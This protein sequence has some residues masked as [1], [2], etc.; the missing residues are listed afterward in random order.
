MTYISQLTKTQ[1]GVLSATFGA[2]AGAAGGYIFAAKKLESFYKERADED[3]AEMKD[4]YARRYKRDD[5][6]DPVDLVK[7]VE[8]IEKSVDT[9]I[10]DEPET[11][12]DEYESKIKEEGYSDSKV[13]AVVENV[14]EKYASSDDDSWD[15]DTEMQRRESTDIYIITD[16]EF[17]NNES[18]Y[19]QSSLSYFVEDD[20]LCDERDQLV[21]NVEE[22][23]GAEN[24]NRFGHG[25]KEPHCVYIRN[26]RLDIE[27]EIVQNQGK[28]SEQVLG[29]IEHSDDDHRIRK[30]RGDRE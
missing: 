23:V 7:T 30:F 13:E 17:L 28:Y 11:E 4:H 19:E 2:M 14:F 25:T 16:E 3:I 21:N 27:V 12:V 22:L 24:L 29:F 20:V 5:Y 8:W 15:W 18:G 10:Q 26:D 6:A 1:V 9:D